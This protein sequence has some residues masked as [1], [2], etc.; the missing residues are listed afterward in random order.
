MHLKPFFYFFLFLP[1]VLFHVLD[2]CARCVP[3]T[4][5]RPLTGVARQTLQKRTTLSGER[6]ERFTI[7][8]F[9]PDVRP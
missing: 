5:P 3:V 8:V 6:E 1:F 7:A 9:N 2:P 4:S